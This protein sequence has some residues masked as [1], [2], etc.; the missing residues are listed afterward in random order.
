M[1]Y[2]VK[3]HLSGC[4]YMGIVFPLIININLFVF[5]RNILFVSIF[6]VVITYLLFLLL[7]LAIITNGEETPGL[8]TTFLT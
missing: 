7:F 4:G 2:M 8:L 3:G 1:V 5:K 6:V